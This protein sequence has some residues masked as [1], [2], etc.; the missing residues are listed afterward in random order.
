M[1][2]L[3]V[4]SGFKLLGTIVWN[5]FGIPN[6]MRILIKISARRI[7]QDFVVFHYHILETHSVP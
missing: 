1:A 6:E 7:Q 5:N 2:L 3:K 4:C